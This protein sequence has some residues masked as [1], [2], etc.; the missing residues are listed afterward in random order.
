[1]TT[2]RIMWGDLL[3]ADERA[4]YQIHLQILDY[5]TVAKSLILKES[6]ALSLSL[7]VADLSQTTSMPRPKTGRYLIPEK[8]QVLSHI[9]AVCDYAKETDLKVNL[10]KTKCML[11]DAECNLPSA[12]WS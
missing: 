7:S 3:L 12:Q 11:F 4:A 10:K 1:M 8:V 2:G 5:L 9:D 6:V